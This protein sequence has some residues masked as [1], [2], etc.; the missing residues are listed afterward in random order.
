MMNCV[1]RTLINLWRK[2]RVVVRNSHLI[3]AEIVVIFIIFLSNFSL[4]TNDKIG[5][6]DRGVYMSVTYYLMPLFLLILF[7]KIYWEEFNNRYVMIDL[8]SGYSRT[9]IISIKLLTGIIYS[10]FILFF[11][12]F[13]NSII[14]YIVKLSIKLFLDS[15]KMV[16][17]AFLNYVLYAAFLNTLFILIFLSFKTK[18]SLKYILWIME[19]GFFFLVHI[20]LAGRTDLLEEY[21][22]FAVIV[23]FNIAILI[24]I[25]KVIDL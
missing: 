3:S 10:I 4:D 22:L 18:S 25:F 20:L 23:A 6:I 1:N 21:L 13:L 7:F 11:P 2:N 15:F 16:V 5:S 9:E 24:R 19:I 8:L 12:F 14:F 17:N